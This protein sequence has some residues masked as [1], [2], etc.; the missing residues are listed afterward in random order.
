[1]KPGILGGKEQD[2][3]IQEKTRIIRKPSTIWRKVY[4]Y[5]NLRQWGLTWETDVLL[6]KS[7]IGIFKPKKNLNISESLDN[8]ENYR[9][10]LDCYKFGFIDIYE[11]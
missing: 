7:M 9:L 4:E 1:M 6:G 2:S 3:R 11:K 10:G 8:Q 5:K